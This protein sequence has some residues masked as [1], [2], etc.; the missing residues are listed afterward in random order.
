[1]YMWKYSCDRALVCV[2]L[3]CVCA[4]MFIYVP[5]CACT[6][7]IMCVSMLG[8][9]INNTDIVSSGSE[10][11]PGN[12]KGKGRRKCGV[13]T[14]SFQRNKHLH[15]GLPVEID[16]GSRSDVSRLLSPGAADTRV[17]STRHRRVTLTHRYIR[18]FEYNTFKLSAV[19]SCHIQCD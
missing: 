10:L 9:G 3:A 11:K 18:S 13:H 1:M 12:C 4:H 6:L 17:L 5:V 15:L 19:T 8:L 7:A 14:Q 16:L 2:R